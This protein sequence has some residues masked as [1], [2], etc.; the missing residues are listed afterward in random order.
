M[1][2]TF[3]DRGFWVSGQG[4]RLRVVELRTVAFSVVSGVPWALFRGLRSVSS[5][6]Y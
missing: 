1:E 6:P 4:C 2:A 3:Y 5:I